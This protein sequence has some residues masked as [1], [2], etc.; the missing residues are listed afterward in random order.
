MAACKRIHRIR[1]FRALIRDSACQRLR[2]C[3]GARLPERAAPLSIEHVSPI[4]QKHP[5]RSV[6]LN[7]F[8]SALY[9]D[10]KIPR[11]ASIER[12]PT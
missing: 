7:D 3:Y 6:L 5:A 2:N 11:L 4:L 8:K 12:K 10:Q 9:T 1:K